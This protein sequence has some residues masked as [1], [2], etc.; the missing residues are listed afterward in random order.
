[1][2]PVNGIDSDFPTQSVIKIRPNFDKR[3]SSKREFSIISASRT[4]TLAF[5]LFRNMGSE[6]EKRLTVGELRKYLTSMPPDMEITFGSSKYRKRPLEFVRCKS[7]GK[8]LLFIELHEI[9]QD[10]DP[11]SECDVRPTVGDFLK[12]LQLWE[13]DCEITFGASI[14]AVP[15]EFRNLSTVVAVNLAQ[16]QEPKWKV[17][18]D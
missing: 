18:G 12:N 7:K 13:D 1:M 17:Q 4:G 5:D 16:N 9:D 6:M 3:N 8:K 11:V 2:F 14:D 15:L 10:S